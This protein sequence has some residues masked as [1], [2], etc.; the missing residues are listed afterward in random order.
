M[1]HLTSR[2]VFA[3][4]AASMAACVTALQCSELVADPSLRAAA[5]GAATL[6]GLLSA[7]GLIESV[8]GAQLRQAASRLLRPRTAA[9][10]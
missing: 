6:V 2:R 1:Q 7:A 9:L 8:V 10:S 4:G 3:L 5:A